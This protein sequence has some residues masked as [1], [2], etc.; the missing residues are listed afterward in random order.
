M[1]YFVHD[2]DNNKRSFAFSYQELK[3]DYE[4]FNSMSNEDFLKN[5]PEILHFTCFICYLK[6][7]PTSCCLSDIGILHELIHLLNNIEL[8]NYSLDKVRENW[9]N[10][11]KLS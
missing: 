3:Q 11:L 8:T 9:N 1:Q 7:I 10:I 6:E 5:L 2:I 4:K